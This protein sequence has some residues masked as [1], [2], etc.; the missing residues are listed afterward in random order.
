MNVRERNST[1]FFSSSSFSSVFFWLVFFYVGTITS[2]RNE[3]LEG[4]C[5]RTDAGWVTKSHTTKDPDL[6]H[7][8]L[9]AKETCV[10]E[11]RSW[12]VCF[13][14]FALVMG[15]VMDVSETCVGVFFLSV[16]V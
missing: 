1:S 15:W 13:L 8:D 7:N 6:T 10:Q 16:C 12:G 9:F 2:V 4:C 11:G 14:F 3:P 5:I